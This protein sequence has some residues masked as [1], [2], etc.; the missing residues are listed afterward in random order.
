MIKKKKKKFI[1]VMLKIWF[2]SIFSNYFYDTRCFKSALN[3]SIYSVTEK[4]TIYII[5][6]TRVRV[7]VFNAT[8]NNISVIA[9]ASMA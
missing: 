3:T 8:F 6:T 7:M 4:L 1:K 9:N 2:S 5:L